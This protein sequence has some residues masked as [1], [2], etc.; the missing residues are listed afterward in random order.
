MSNT[1]L[2]FLWSVFHLAAATFSVVLL[3][4]R[5]LISGE[6]ISSKKFLWVI[7]DWRFIL[8]MLLAVL[9]RATFVMVNNSLLKIPGLA[10]ASTSITT[11]I[12]QFAVVFIVIANIIFL[13]ERISLH[14]G[15]GMAMVLTGL[16]LVL[17]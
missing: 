3:G 8:S 9:A 11:I 17:K 12:S 7:T 4:S 16:F 15:I 6:L 13:Q 2:V 1:F 14:Q 10:D 5:E